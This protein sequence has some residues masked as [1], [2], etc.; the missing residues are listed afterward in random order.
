MASIVLP[1]TNYSTGP[2]IQIGVNLTLFAGAVDSSGN[3]LV[4]LVDTTNPLIPVVTPYAVPAGITNMTVAGNLLHVTAGAAGYAV[5]QIPGVT[6]IQYSL[7]GNCG[8]PVNFSISP[9]TQGTISASGLYT[10]PAAITPGQTV[11]VTATGQ[12][13]PTQT[14]SA[15]V[16]L[17]TSVP[18]LSLGASTP[19]PYIVG[20][21]ATFAATLTSGGAPVPGVTVTLAVTGANARTVTAVTAANGVASLSYSGATRGAD[22][23]QASANSV[24]S[25]SL[26]ALWVGPSTSFTTTPVTGEFF[27]AASCPSGCEAFTTPKTQVPAFLQTFPDLMFNPAGTTSTTRSFADLILGPTGAS[28]G[29]ILAQGNGHVAGAGDMLG[30]SA[31][32]TGS[33]VVAQAGSYTINVTSQDGFIF[34]VGSGASRVSG[35]DINPPASGTTVFSQYPV[36]GANSGPSTGAASPIIVSFP[37]AGSY[38]Y[39]FDYKSG[40]GGSLSFTVTTTQGSSSLGIPPLESLVLTSSTVSL[41]TGQ[42]AGFT[43]KATDETGAPIASLPVTVTVAGVNPQTLLA[44]TNS[45]GVATLTYVGV[46]TGAASSKP[47]PLPM[48]CRS[49][50]AS[51]LLHGP[52]PTH[53]RSQSPATLW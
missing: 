34:G 24:A 31:V 51:P 43:V 20:G 37:P 12:S 22:A 53:R 41:L 42:P 27:T 48:A 16:N 26:S 11:V 32:F 39:E 50:P 10:A 23:I 8:G 2:A 9:L 52:P 7:T 30:F 18:T 3:N 35:V 29:S 6:A 45:G 4:L 19:S 1:Y 21:S 36:M 40:T 13:D 33:F 44:T 28:T 15:I 5:Y 46:H 38:A 25:N 17:S 47:P 49:F 14:A